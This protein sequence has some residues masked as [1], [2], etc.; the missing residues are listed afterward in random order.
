MNS[1]LIT[2]TVFAIVFAPFA[3]LMLALYV[4]SRRPV[5]QPAAPKPSAW[6][7][8]P[9]A[10]QRWMAAAGLVAL[11]GLG[12]HGQRIYANVWID[13][14]VWLL[15]PLF[16]GAAFGHWQAAKMARADHS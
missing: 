16:L 10:T 12:S 2:I 11:M 4:R 9:L 13:R 1:T 14:I 5:R 3:G 6:T 8:L 7:A 15:V